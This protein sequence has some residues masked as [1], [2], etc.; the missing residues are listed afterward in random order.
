MIRGGAHTAQPLP[1]EGSGGG[2]A[3]SRTGVCDIAGNNVKLERPWEHYDPHESKKKQPMGVTA[4]WQH[5]D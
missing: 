3:V 5:M 2:V 4:S 1:G